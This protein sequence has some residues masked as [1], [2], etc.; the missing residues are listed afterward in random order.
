MLPQL[1]L[2]HWSILKML[3]AVKVLCHTL[4]PIQFMLCFVVVAWFKP[5]P[6]QFEIGKPAQV[7]CEQLFESAG[8]HSFLPIHQLCC[9]CVYSTMKLHDENLLVNI[10]VP[11][12]EYI[13]VHQFSNT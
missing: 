13:Y 1:H 4:Y 10:V 3:H 11:L 12:V 7:W 5:H 6:S 2:Q 8:L 9:R